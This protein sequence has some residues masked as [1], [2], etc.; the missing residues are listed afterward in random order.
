MLPTIVFLRHGE[1][2]WNVE[3][4]LQGQRDISLN[5]NGRAQ[6]KRNGEAIRAAVADIADFDFVASPLER[7]RETMEIARLAMGLDPSAFHLDDRLREIT[8]GD[9]EGFTLAELRATHPDLVA[10]REQDKWSFLPPGGESYEQL[11]E[12]VQGWLATISRPTMAVSH[13][14]VGRVLRRYLHDLDPQ[15]AVTM[16]F[17]QDQAMLIKNGSTEWI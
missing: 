4:R 1:T 14:G 15:A 2:N 12:R 11:S 8:F 9:W 17:P 13:G 5:D 3:G 10:A 7:S 16:S 6:A